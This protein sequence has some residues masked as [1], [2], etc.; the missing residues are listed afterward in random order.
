MVHFAKYS[1]YNPL[2]RFDVYPVMGELNGKEVKYLDRELEYNELCDFS[3]GKCLMKMQGTYCWRGMWEGR[4]YFSDDEYWGEEIEEL[5]RLYND[6]I[7]RLCRG[8]IKKMFPP[9]TDFSE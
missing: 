7:V 9:D 2:I 5:S 6:H 3:K 8:F 1:M 4:L